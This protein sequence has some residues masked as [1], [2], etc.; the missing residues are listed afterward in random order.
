MKLYKAINTISKLWCK[1]NKNLG[2]FNKCEARVF[3]SGEEGIKKAIKRMYKYEYIACPNCGKRQRA[4][5]TVDVP[6]EV[7]IHDCISCDYTIMESEWD[8]G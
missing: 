8:N 1:N 6:F 7:K 5:V 4:K 3:K 2:L